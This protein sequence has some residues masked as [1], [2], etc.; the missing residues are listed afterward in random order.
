MIEP[1]FY[2]PTNRQKLRRW[3]ARQQRA[4]AASAS[5]APYVVRPRFGA[6][7]WLLAAFLCLLGALAFGIHTSAAMG[8][9]DLEGAGWFAVCGVSI[10]AAVLL[11]LRA[12]RAGYR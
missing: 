11:E 3:Y 1:G 8:W 4:T 12:L 7:V 10:V 5:V 9:H 2:P 6:A